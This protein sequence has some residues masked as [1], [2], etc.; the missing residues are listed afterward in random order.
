MKLY[1][2]TAEGRVETC[3][4]PE[5][6][7]EHVEGTEEEIILPENNPVE[8]GKDVSYKYVVTDEV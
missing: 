6:C 1:R 8:V 5:S 4:A 3:Q 7:W 2:I